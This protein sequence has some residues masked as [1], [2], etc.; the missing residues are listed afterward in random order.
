VGRRSRAQTGGIA[1][2]GGI[3]N[4]SRGF[5]LSEFTPFFFNEKE[6]LPH[7]SAETLVN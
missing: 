4:V 7:L 6:K 2:T 3:S 5:S 1:P